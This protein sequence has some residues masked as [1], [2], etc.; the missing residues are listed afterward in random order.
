[1]KPH[2]KSR[3]EPPLPPIKEEPVNETLGGTDGEDQD[4]DLGQP[5]EAG[6]RDFASPREIDTG[7]DQ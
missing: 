5:A 4:E 2:K 1:M 6:E 3:P 7:E